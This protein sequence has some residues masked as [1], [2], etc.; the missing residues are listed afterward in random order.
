MGLGPLVLKVQAVKYPQQCICSSLCEAYMP[1]FQAVGSTTDFSSMNLFLFV[2]GF[3]VVN[4]DHRSL[5][6]LV[7]LFP[8]LSLAE[9]HPQCLKLLSHSSNEYL[10]V[11]KGSQLCLCWAPGRLASLQAP[12]FVAVLDF[13]SPIRYFKMIFANN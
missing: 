11:C 9:R 5:W 2:P 10:G 1:G 4:C 3:S 8:K 13:Y 7:D 12:Q 6:K